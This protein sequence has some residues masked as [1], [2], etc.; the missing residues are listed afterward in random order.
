MTITLTLN[1]GKLTFI[2][3]KN[4][5]PQPPAA[6]IHREKFNDQPHGPEQISLL[7]VHAPAGYGKTTTVADRLN[8][9]E[10]ATAWY[11]LEASDNDPAKFAGYLANALE[12]AA[13]GSCKETLRKLQD[14]GYEHL[15]SFL[16]DLL[17]ELPT[18]G[19]KPLYLVLDDYHLIDNEIIHN[20]LRFLLRHQPVSLTLVLV[21]RTLPPI[22]I[23]QLR[24][25]G[26]MAEITSRD[27]A[28]GAD[29]AQH[30]FDSRLPFE[31]SRESIER[32]V[33]RVEGWVSA[34]QLLSASVLTRLEFNNFVDQLEH[35]NQ[36]IFDYFD[37]LVS[38]GL[39]D[40]QRTFQIGRA[41][42]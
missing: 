17:A 16:T 36:H 30:Y 11:R 35:G 34:L 3:A 14:K 1:P 32:A 7:L 29:E 21:S 42:V 39:T 10:A 19:E 26:R 24:M 5:S 33:R 13:P 22:G 41:H 2:S 18:I 37:E 28:F 15:E 40:Q 12:T 8:A 6:L 25:Q 27:L 23:A 31:V 20:G 38:Q 4:Q 9:R